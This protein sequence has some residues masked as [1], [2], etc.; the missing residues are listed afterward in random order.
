VKVVTHAGQILVLEIA[1]EDLTG[2]RI[3]DTFA[4]VVSRQAVVRE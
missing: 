4:L 1:P 2:M 3:G